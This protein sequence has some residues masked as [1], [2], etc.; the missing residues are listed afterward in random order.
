MEDEED[1]GTAND[2]GSTAVTVLISHSQQKIIVA[3]LGDSRAVAAYAKKSQPKPP[4][5]PK[6]KMAP[7]KPKEVIE[8]KELS[9]DHKPQNSREALRVRQAGGVVTEDGRI[10]G[11]ISLSRALG[12]L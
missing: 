5:A 10:N 2:K 7:P 6:S 1:V 9:H 4:S 8:I 11:Q 3:N 12:D